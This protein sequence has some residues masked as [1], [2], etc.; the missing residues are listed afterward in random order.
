MATTVALSLSGCLVYDVVSTDEMERLESKVDNQTEEIDQLEVD[1]QQARTD[2]QAVKSELETLE[3]QT[4]AE[5]VER[6]H[7][8]Y[9]HATAMADEGLENRVTAVDFWNN[10]NYRLA[11][12]ASREGEANAGAAATI[13]DEV[14]TWGEDAETVPDA[15]VEDATD[16]REFAR[17]IRD[18]NGEAKQ[19]AAKVIA[20]E[21]STS[22]INDHLDSA[23]T[24]S[25]QAL[26]VDVADVSA[27]RS[28]LESSG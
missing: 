16:A 15:A 19:A 4:A 18:A 1:L 7:T 9:E 8:L 5:R 27:F 14:V 26:D 20:D 13:L 11:Y 3:E 24:M 23:S 12:S 10:E 21:G 22:E 2:R 6:L 17:L 28:A 25:Q